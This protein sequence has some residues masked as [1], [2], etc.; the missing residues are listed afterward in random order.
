MQTNKN[1]IAGKYPRLEIAV[2]DGLDEDTIRLIDKYWQI[3]GTDFVYKIKDIQ[4]HFYFTQP[5]ITKK[6]SN[7]SNA[8][9]VLERCSKCNDEIKFGLEHRSHCYELLKDEL[10][11]LLCGK[12][13]LA[14][15]Y[16]YN[17]NHN[18]TRTEF[19]LQYFFE[20]KIWDKLAQDEQDFLKQFLKAS[21]YKKILKNLQGTEFDLVWKRIE[22]L[23]CYGILHFERDTE[24]KLV[25][26]I[27]HPDLRKELIGDLYD[28]EDEISV[29]LL[30]KGNRSYSIQP[31]YTRK[32][33]FDKDVVLKAGV[34]FMC[35]M[36]HN[37]DGSVLVKLT[38]L[39]QIQRGNTR[40]EETMQ[41]GLLFKK[42]IK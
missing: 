23:E 20:I 25:N 24:N 22:K 17:A 30:P 29:K 34:D 14:F 5:E 8:V 26:I 32:I 28:R 3:N 11:R 39:S 4:S 6:V 1:Q 10:L 19:R 15:N 33:Q 12:C 18:P 37:E 31:H 13:Q 36:W 41:A 42:I 9:L 27:Y 40:D 7:L 2:E 35:S 21:S 16:I 38:P